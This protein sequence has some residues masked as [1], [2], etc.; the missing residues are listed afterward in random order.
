M[1]GCSICAIA[2]SQEQ[3]TGGGNGG[4]ASGGSADSFGDDADS[5][6]GA[7]GIGGAGGSGSV[8]LTNTGNNYEDVSNSAEIEQV[9]EQ[10]NKDCEGSNCSNR[11][12]QVQTTGGGNGG[13]AK[14]RC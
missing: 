12:S 2:I 14:G 5:S 4:D 6:G 10:E 8:T 7:G 1:Q 13:D 11:I 3:S 9:A